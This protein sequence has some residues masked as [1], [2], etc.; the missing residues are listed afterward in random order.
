MNVI[1]PYGDR[2]DDGAV[3]LAFSLPVPAG[4]KAKEA[5]AQLAKQMGFHTILVASMEAAGEN[6]STFVVYARGAQSVDF[7]KIDLT[8]KTVKTIPMRDPEVIEDVTA[9]AK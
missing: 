1:R 5:A 4:P 9:A 6:F 2:R 8:A 3:Q 7:D